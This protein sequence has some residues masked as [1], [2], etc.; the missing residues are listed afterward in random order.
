MLNSFCQNALICFFIITTILKLNGISQTKFSFISS[1]LDDKFIPIDSEELEIAKEQAKEMFFFGYNNYLKYAFP[2]DELDPIHCKGRGPDYDNPNNLNINDVLGDYSLTLIDSLNTLVIVGNKDAFHNA[3]KLVINNVSFEKN[4]TIQV[5]E[6]TI[7]IIGSLL[8]THMILTNENPFHGNFSF[9]EYNS[10]LLT[11]AHDIAGR[12]LPAFSGTGT[13]LPYPRVNLI[14]GVLPG[15]SNETCTAGAGSLLL[16]FGVLSRLLNDPTFEEKARRVNEILWEFRNKETGL[17]GNI[18]DIQTGEWKSLMAGMGAGFDSFFE[19]L[20]KAHILF[21][22]TRELEMF[23]GMRKSIREQ[24]RRGR[25][26]CRLGDGNPPLYPNVD[27]RDGSIINT[28][29][30]ALQVQVLLASKF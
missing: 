2:L 4:V 21:G 8:S 11:M 14:H 25:S 5:F 16:E 29:L 26:K 15:T 24:I 13:G 19:Y 9:P 30:D 18:I 28:W 17:M 20:L 6:A 12:L 10:E 22:E 27:M 7:R 1:N 23:L 3:V